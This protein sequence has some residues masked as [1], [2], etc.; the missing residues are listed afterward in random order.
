MM[1]EIR[2]YFMKR[3]ASNKKKISTFK[4]TICPQI[5]KRIE[6]EAKKTKYWLPR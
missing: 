1:E 6:E 3:W 2:I 5:K 4:G